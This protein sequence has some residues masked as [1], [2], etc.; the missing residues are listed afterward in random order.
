MK[1]FTFFDKIQ[2]QFADDS[3]QMM[4]IFNRPSAN[5]SFEFPIS[6]PYTYFIEDG[7]TPDDVARKVYNDDNYFWFV[8]L[9]NKIVDFYKEW[10]SSYSHWKDQLLTIYTADTFFS[11]HK[12]DVQIGD[13]VSKVGTRE[14]AG[15]TLEIDFENAGVVSGVDPF[16]RSFDVHRIAGEI[17]ENNNYWILRKSGFSYRKINPPNSTAAHVL[18]RKELKLNAGVEFYSIDSKNNNIMISPYSDPSGTNLVS[19]GVDNIFDYPDTILSK[20]I[21]KELPGYIIPRSFSDEKEREWLFK[22]NIQVIP[23]SNLTNLNNAYSDLFVKD[24]I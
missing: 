5:V 19:S 2:Y 3:L 13:I 23:I 22:K 18:Y 1:Y 10:P 9:Q 15:V 4:N 24:S 8:L 20:Y 12:L 17:K 6:Q 16:L 7:N 14:I 11:P 21:K